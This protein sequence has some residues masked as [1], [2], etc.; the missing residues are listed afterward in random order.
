MLSKARLKYRKIKEGLKR[1]TWGLKT[2]DQRGLGFHG[3]LD[4]HLCSST[5]SVKPDVLILIL[6]S[7]TKSLSIDS[8]PMSAFIELKL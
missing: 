8:Q 6:T 1:G 7:C 4:L 3:H 5:R 2:W